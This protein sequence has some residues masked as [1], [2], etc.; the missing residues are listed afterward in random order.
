LPPPFPLLP[1]VGLS[2]QASK[3]G[4]SRQRASMSGAGEDVASCLCESAEQ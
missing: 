2:L 3:S 1:L 4:L